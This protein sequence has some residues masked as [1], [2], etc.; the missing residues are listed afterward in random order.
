M[1]GLNYYINVY[2][3][4]S[5]E[6]VCAEAA[7]IDRDLALDAIIYPDDRVY[8]N[9]NPQKNLYYAHT[10]ICQ[11]GLVRAEDWSEVADSLYQAALE[12]A[13]SHADYIKEVSSP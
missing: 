6:D 12:E 11:D 1:K 4:G 5:G 10:I 13:Q 3:N 8:K 2:M 7:Y 9:S